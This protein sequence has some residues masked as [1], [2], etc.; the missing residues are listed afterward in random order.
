MYCIIIHIR[1]HHTI[2]TNTSIYYC[3]TQAHT[4]A[5]THAR[6]HTRMHKHTHTCTCTHTRARAHTHT[7]TRTHA[8]THA[9]THAQTHTHMHMH[10]HTRTRAHTH[11]HTHT[12]STGQRG[13]VADMGH[14][15]HN[16]LD[17]TH[18]LDCGHSGGPLE[19]SSSLACMQ[20]VT[21]AADHTVSS[22]ASHE[23]YGSLP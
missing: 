10:T 22:R 23:V 19:S 2:H 12:S 18:T 7:H 20:C 9:H 14:S 5:C 21:E 17:P 15:S 3:T 1:L 16:P 4:H 6:T 13:A 8:R 11:I